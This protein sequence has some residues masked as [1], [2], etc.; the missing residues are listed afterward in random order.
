M[1]EEQSDRLRELAAKLLEMTQPEAEGLMFQ[2]RAQ[3]PTL[4]LIAEG[5]ARYDPTCLLRAAQSEAARR[6]LRKRFLPS[7]WFS[8]GP[9]NI[10]IDLFESEQMGRDVSITDA[11]IA[12]D[13]PSTTAIRNIG[14]LVA[15]GLVHRRPDPK[16]SRRCFLRLTHEGAST[17][18]TMLSSMLDAEVAIKER[19]KSAKQRKA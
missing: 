14:Q 2:H 4:D 13:V 3:E 8:E 16:D 7:D 6:R 9:W 19:L 18:R 15:A 12:A 11:C 10:L 1:N 5:T 17:I